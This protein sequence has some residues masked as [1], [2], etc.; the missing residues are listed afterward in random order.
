VQILI[1]LGGKY[2]AVLC[3]AVASGPGAAI[4]DDDRFSAAGNVSLLNLEF[5]EVGEDLSR[6]S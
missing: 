6:L 2:R 1:E 4:A 3:G 5:H